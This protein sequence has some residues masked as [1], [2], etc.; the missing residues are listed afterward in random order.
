MKIFT[1]NIR[2][3]TC[4]ALAF[5]GALLSACTPDDEDLALGPKPEPAA[6]T[7]TDISTPERKNT[8]VLESSNED[9]FFFQ[10]DL[11]QGSV[12]FAGGRVDTVHYE[13]RGNYTIKLVTLSKGGGGHSTTSKELVVE[14]DAVTGTNAIKGGEMTQEQ[15]WNF[16]NTGSTETAYSFS[17]GALTFT[18]DNPAQSNIAMWQEVELKGGRAYNLAAT[19]KGSG[20]SNSW[21]EIF[22]LKEAPEEGVDPSG[23][24]IAG[25][26]TWTGCGVEP[27]E[28]ALTS[29]SCLGDGSVNIAEDGT[30]Y[31]VFKVGSWDGTLGTE[32]LT[33]D[34]VQFIAQPRLVEGANIL[35]GSGMEDESAWNITDM[36][37]ALTDVDFVD[38]VMKFTNGNPAQ[39]NVGVWQQVE[40]AADQIYKLKADV[41]NPE[42]TNSWVEFYVSPTEPVDGVDYSTGRVE[43][44]NTKSFAEAG[45]VYVLVKV[46]SWD[47]TLGPN[48]V[49]V[50][51]VE[52][53]EMR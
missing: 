44:G 53:V 23:A 3:Q 28:G 30:Y 14:E 21:L 37:L 49:T 20:M 15:A 29:I 18:N 16:Y 2:L 9:A 5:A 38:G 47:G 34:N 7:I 22:L 25:L 27:F 42:S 4:A 24:V 1:Y 45:T 17:N 11:G 51:N 36:G 46:G 26:N 52:L 43:P 50:D 40:V 10:W 32:G 31:L 13:E 39:T 6:F 8:Y 33:I 48:G 12:P 35:Q 19:I 41:K